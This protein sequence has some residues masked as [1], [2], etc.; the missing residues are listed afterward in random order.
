MSE[1]LGGRSEERRIA[2]RR[3][4]D[5]PGGPRDADLV[6]PIDQGN[7]WRRRVAWGVAWLVLTALVVVSLRTVEW[8]RVGSELRH[9]KVP[10]LVV[11]LAGNTLIIVCWTAL[12]RVFVPGAQPVSFGTM[13]RI[14]AITSAVMNT[15]P[16][17]VG[18]A[19]GVALLVRRGGLTSSSALSVIALDQLAEGIAKVLTFLIAALLLP[20]PD[21]MRRSVMGVAAA[22]GVMLVVLLVFAHVHKPR[23]VEQDAA[24]VLEWQGTDW[25]KRVW[26]FL[27]RWARD[28][29][30]LRDWKKAGLS[31]LFAVAMKSSEA[32]GIFAVQRALGVDLPLS[33]LPVVLAA[34]MLATMIPLSPG[35]LGP[36]EAAT[37]VAYR[38][39]GLP[40]D[41]ALSLA[42]IQHLAFLLPA[43]G[44]GYTIMSFGWAK[45]RAAERRAAADGEIDRWRS[46]GSG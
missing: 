43:L 8:S 38:F 18:H 46:E 17:L 32:L 3:V 23:D 22:V 10:W 29:E 26:A 1:A 36:Y 44:G 21:W 42:L 34:V 13:F 6:R 11:A 40:T 7:P 19:S 15:T 25:R 35:N 5:E 28:L 24:E 20:L 30:A 12:W 27:R 33:T 14:N 4:Q 37:L 41:Q 31:L 9:V 45:E 39:L 16:L 2:H